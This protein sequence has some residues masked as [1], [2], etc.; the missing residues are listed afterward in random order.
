MVACHLKLIS[1]R[2][3][4]QTHFQEE[5][6]YIHVG[7]E[8]WVSGGILVFTPTAMIHSFTDVLNISWALFI[9]LKAAEVSRVP[10][11]STTG[12][13]WYGRGAQGTSSHFSTIHT[14]HLPC[15]DLPWGRSSGQ[16]FM[17]ELK[18]NQVL[19]SVTMIP[20]MAV[21]SDDSVT[22]PA[23]QGRWWDIDNLL[24]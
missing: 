2:L 20:E 11:P 9:A 24:I 5:S 17:W 14:L 8:S 4:I 12:W 13:E 3:A 18:E 10:V 22:V 21:W 19:P 7:A 16:P 6:S 15:M 23:F 1:E